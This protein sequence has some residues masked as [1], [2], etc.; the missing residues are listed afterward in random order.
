MNGIKAH[1]AEQP[2]WDPGPLYLRGYCRVCNRHFFYRNRLDTD[3]T[4]FH[5]HHAGVCQRCR[6]SCARIKPRPRIA[7]P[8]PE[9]EVLAAMPAGDL[10]RK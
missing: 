10:G 3:H 1:E 2:Q 7:I 6:Y 9:G 4:Q 8:G 5:Q